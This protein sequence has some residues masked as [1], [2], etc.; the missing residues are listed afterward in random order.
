MDK[1]CTIISI[2]CPIKPL[3]NA[4]LCKNGTLTFTCSLHSGSTVSYPAG[5]NFYKSSKQEVEKGRSHFPSHLVNRWE[6]LCFPSL[7]LWVGWT[8]CS[9]PQMERMVSGRHGKSPIEIS[10]TAATWASYPPVLRALQARRGVTTS[11]GDTDSMKQEQ[12]S[13]STVRVGNNSCEPQRN[14]LGGSLFFSTQL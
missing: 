6:I 11:A 12:G 13:C 2:C 14:L 7:Q 4:T 9:G 8:V 1:G 3:L 5:Q 10:V